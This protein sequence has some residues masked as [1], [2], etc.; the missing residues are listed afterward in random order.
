MIVVTG[1]A[2]CIGSAL[3][4]GLNRRG[5]DDILIVDR[6]G[7][8]DKWRNLVGLRFAD[9]LDKGDFIAR[10]EGGA[11]KNGISAILH[12]GACSSTLERDAG[13][14]IENNYRYTARLAAWREKHPSCRFIYASSAA[15]YGD[16]SQGYADDHDRLRDLRPLNMYGYSKHLF[17]LLA[18]R[19]GWLSQ[20]VGLKYFNVYGPNEDHKGA[21][22]SVVHKAYAT[23]RDAGVMRLFKSY[24][25]EYG[26]GEQCR[27]F[28]YVK[29]AVELTLFFLEHPK[30]NGIFNVGAGKA[31]TWN[32]VAR[33]L[34][35][36]A[37]KPPKIEYIP[38]PEELRGK[39]QY[40][41]C[42]DMTK[43]RSAGCGH[44]CMTL[45]E[46]VRDYVRGYLAVGRR[47]GITTD[48][49]ASF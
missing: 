9:Y 40:H 47:L 32:E 11:F 35:D 18:L 2:G 31:R 33:A 30:V 15:T 26:D 43:L 25:A 23:V 5:S 24:R 17:D 16:G 29:D 6:L 10:L 21:M 27:D 37:G 48:Q 44:Q 39:Y 46:G 28:L 20:C 22:R 36:A 7:E 41:T 34:F 1:G 4:W 19:K 13:Y 42:A 12:L 3:V 45:E 8:D 38:M 14:L 49:G